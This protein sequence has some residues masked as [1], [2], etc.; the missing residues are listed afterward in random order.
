MNKQQEL[1]NKAAM[2]DL[3]SGYYKYNDPSKHIHFYQ[4]HLKY[5]N[6]AIREQQMDIYRASQPSYVRVLHAV[7]DAPNVDVYINANRVLRDVAFKDISDYLTLP[8]G[9][10]HIDIYP[11][12]TGVSTLISKKVKIEPGKV[13]TL[14]AAGTSNKLQL[15]PYLDDPAVPPGETKLKFIHLSP[16]APS[17]DIGV[18]GGDTVFADISYKEAS[19]Y[20]TLTPMTV[21]L[22][23]RKAGTKDKVLDIPNV[24]LE[25]NQSYTVVAVGLVEGTP[26]LEVLLLKG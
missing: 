18:K 13:Y 20:L 12:G 2:Y 11:A 8:A 19:D 16:D 23:A 17:V 14:A 5:M 21:N 25:P 3:L 10:Y 4:K 9:K 22:E 24:K 7:P 6:A 15:L 26:E 1:L